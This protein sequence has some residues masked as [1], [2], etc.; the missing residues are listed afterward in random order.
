VSD[1]SPGPIRDRALRAMG[2][3]L[4]GQLGQQ[5]ARLAVVITL[6]RLLVPNDF[7]LVTMVGTLTGFATVF[8]EAGI[9]NA[10][11]QR[12]VLTD[13]HVATAAWLTLALGVLFAGITAAASPLIAAFF[14]RHALEALS[15]G[16]AVDFIVSAPGLVPG[17]LLA[18]ELRFRR[19]V[20]AELAGVVVGGTAAIVHA[21]VR[22]SPWPMVTFLIGSDLVTSIILSTA[23]SSRLRVRPDRAA[24][25]ELWQFSGGLLGYTVFNYWSRNAD[26]LLIGRV[27]GSAALGVYSRCYVILLFPVQQ[28]AQVVNR[29]MFPAMSTVQDDHSR[30]RSA[31]LRTIAVVGLLVFP[32]TVL[33]FVGAHPFVIGVL[34]KQWHAAIPVLRVFSVVAAIQSI[35]TTTGWLYQATGQT[36]RMFRV[37]IVL[38][39]LVI[40]GFVIGVQ[41][42]LMGVV[43][44]YLAWNFVSLPVNA[45][46]SGRAVDL[47]PKAFL[48]AVATPFAL[49]VVLC[50]LLAVVNIVLPTMPDLARLGALVAA[51]LVLYAVELIVVKPAAWVDLLTAVGDVRRRPSDSQV[52]EVVW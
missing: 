35:G 37:T 32:A 18:R 36:T 33:L 23:V 11:I 34:G 15:I 49:S 43:Y 1:G 48:S 29:V 4:S 39:V 14:H 17:A 45:V 27:V 52:S 26:N 6:S 44:S 41:W 30:V 13:K 42:G 50:G 47:R 38:T 8:T 51:G 20:I 12:K 28:V 21:V 5:A 9:S 7:G 22:P 40:T 3:T 31:Y 46:Y 10:L 25:G 16:F 19:V 2:W 24:F